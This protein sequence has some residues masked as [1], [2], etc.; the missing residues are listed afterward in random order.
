M[1][2]DNM[3]LSCHIRIFWIAW[4]KIFYDNMVKEAIV[5][6]FEFIMHDFGHIIYDLMTGIL[7]LDLNV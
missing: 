6:V 3:S 4:C 2:D 7:N 5:F 1:L